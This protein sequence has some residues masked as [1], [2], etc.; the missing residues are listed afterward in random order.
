VADGPPYD[1]RHLW[2]KGIIGSPQ[3]KQ[4]KKPNKYFYYK[5]IYTYLTFYTNNCSYPIYVFDWQKKPIYY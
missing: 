1:D 5:Q 3:K 4:Y 2:W